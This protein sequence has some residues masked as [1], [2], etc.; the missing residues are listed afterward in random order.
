MNE[1]IFRGLASSFSMHPINRKD[2]SLSEF[3]KTSALRIAVCIQKK[4]KL[5]CLHASFGSQSWQIVSKKVNYNEEDG[6]TRQEH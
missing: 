4:I 5:K 6:Y 1:L 2:C 3:T